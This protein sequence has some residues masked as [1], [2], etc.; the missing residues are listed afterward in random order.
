MLTDEYGYVLKEVGFAKIYV[1][2]ISRDYAL[3][4]LRDGKLYH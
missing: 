3:L 2:D 1:R 4:E